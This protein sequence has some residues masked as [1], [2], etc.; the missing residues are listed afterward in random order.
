MSSP[1]D[2][3]YTATVEQDPDDSYWTYVRVCGGK[4][5][6]FNG[7]D[8]SLDEVSNFKEV[9]LAKYCEWWPDEAAA[10]LAALRAEKAKVAA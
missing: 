4:V 3:Y 6:T 10:E 7:F 9:S 1:R 2:G 8:L 5:Q